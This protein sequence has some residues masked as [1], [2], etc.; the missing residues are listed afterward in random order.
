MMHIQY[1]PV[2]NYSVGGIVCFGFTSTSLNFCFLD[3]KTRWLEITV[4]VGQII[5]DIYR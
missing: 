1:R 2:G 5:T 3:R 4:S